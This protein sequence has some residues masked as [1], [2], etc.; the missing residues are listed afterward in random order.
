M[1]AGKGNIYT[2]MNG[3]KQFIIPVYQRLYSW[4]IDQC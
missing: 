3:S 1:D 2:I 4:D